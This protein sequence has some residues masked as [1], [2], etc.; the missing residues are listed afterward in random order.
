M[1]VLK[2]C[3]FYKRKNVRCFLHTCNQRW[4]EVK[5]NL[6]SLNISYPIRYS[7]KSILKKR[8]KAF[9]LYEQFHIKILFFKFF[10]IFLSPWVGLM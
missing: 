2:W 7:N 3:S 8:A 9:T 5:R 1:G 10:Q 4:G 6:A